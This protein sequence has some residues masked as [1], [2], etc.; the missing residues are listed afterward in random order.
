MSGTPWTFCTTLSGMD[1]CNQARHPAPDMRGMARQPA[2]DMPGPARH[3]ARAPHP[4]RTLSLTLG[5]SL[6]L[7]VLSAAGQASCWRRVQPREPANVS[8]PLLTGI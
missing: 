5:L 4:S 1:V 7:S 3:S 6:T 2:A 8:L